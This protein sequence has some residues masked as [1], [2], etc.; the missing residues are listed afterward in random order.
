MLG[1]GQEVVGNPLGPLLLAGS[2]SHTDNALWVV[3]S[4]MG[5]VRRGYRQASESLRSLAFGV[6][7]EG[8]LFRQRRR[9]KALVTRPHWPR[10][11]ET[12]PPF[13]TV[14][15]HRRSIKGERRRVNR[16]LAPGRVQ[17]NVTQIMKIY[18]P[19]LRLWVRVRARQMSRDVLR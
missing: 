14:S 16:N 15:K 10:I 18:S 1:R 3:R 19:R 11:S 4:V 7:P 2:S 6:T 17:S 5:W 9:H 13:C 12:P 8:D